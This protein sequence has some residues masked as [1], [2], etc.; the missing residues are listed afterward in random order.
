MKSLKSWLKCIDSNIEKTII[1]ISYFIMTL[2]IVTEVIKRFC[3][4]TQSPWSTQVP[5]YLFLFLTWFSAAY[6]VKA[7]THLNFITLRQK[8]SPRG[9]WLC[10]I[11]D[12]LCWW[13]LGILVIRYTVEQVYLNYSMFAMVFG[14]ELMSWYFMLSTP[15]GWILILYR[16][17]QNLIQDTRAY[18]HNEEIPLAGV[19]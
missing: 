11:L 13:V 2:I 18:F 1:I 6:N 5:L 16:A 14:T 8:F 10:S 17:T 9:R 15:L 7:R 4:H 3:F 19:E 12:C